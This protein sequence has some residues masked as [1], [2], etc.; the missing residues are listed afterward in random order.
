MT[1]PNS[2]DRQRRGVRR[3]VLLL[4]I[5]AVAIYGMFLMSGMQ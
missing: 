3:T 4:A 5:I 2:S 1:P